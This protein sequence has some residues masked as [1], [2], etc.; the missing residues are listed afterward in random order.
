MKRSAD[1]AEWTLKLPAEGQ[2]KLTYTVQVE[3]PRAEK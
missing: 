1:L 2:F 3:V